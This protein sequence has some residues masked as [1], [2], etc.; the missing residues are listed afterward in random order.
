MEKRLW[1]YHLLAF[2]VVAI[3]GITFV[4]TKVLISAGLEPAQI[5]AGRFIIA[6]AGMLLLS[7]FGKEKRRLWGDNLRDELMFAL[8]GIAGGSFYFLTENTA[9]EYTQACNVSF[10]VSSSPL[11]TLFLSMA[12][13]KFGT[14]RLAAGQEKVRVNG[15]LVGGTLLAVAGM[16]AVIFNGTSLSLS[17]KGDFLALGAALCWGAYSVLMGVASKD[18]GTLFLTRKV[19]FYGLLTIIPFLIGRESP[20]REVLLRPEVI[21]NLVFLGTVASLA[22]FV[23]WNKVVAELGNVTATNYV[24]LNPFFTLIFAML[25]LGESL[26]PLAAAGSAAIVLGVFLAGKAGKS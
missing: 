7:L 11:L 23:L 5:F 25:L 16:A 26:T 3:W 12:A 24:Y 1:K 15:W 22:C 8:L 6:Y 20:G 4:S 13:R 2:L 18:Y 14:G 19:F 21:F 17:P 9:L 10:L